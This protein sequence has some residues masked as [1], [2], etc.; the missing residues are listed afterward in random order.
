MRSRRQWHTQELLLCFLGEMANYLAMKNA[1]VPVLL[2]SSVWLD[3]TF[4]AFVTDLQLY[5]RNQ[6]NM[7]YLQTFAFASSSYWH[8]A[9]FYQLWSV[10]VSG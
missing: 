5:A 10:L 6:L 3:N 1:G 7:K 8:I 4:V 2:S 9:R